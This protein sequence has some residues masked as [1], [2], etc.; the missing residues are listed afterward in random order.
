M[1][2][3]TDT[4][5]DDQWQLVPKEPTDEIYQ[6]YLNPGWN[7]YSMWGRMLF[8][9]PTP[10]VAAPVEVTGEALYQALK[11][12]LPAWHEDDWDDLMPEFKES[13]RAAAAAL[14][15]RGEKK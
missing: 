4:Y 2:Q 7:F 10:P 1:S 9:A 12:Q 11:A 8:A 5:D 13:Y 3:R 6:A 15:Q 14:A